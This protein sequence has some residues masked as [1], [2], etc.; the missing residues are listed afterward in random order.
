M[1]LLYKRFVYRIEIVCLFV[2]RQA[3]HN[4]TSQELHIYSPS[5]THRGSGGWLLY[6]LFIIFSPHLTYGYPIAIHRWIYALVPKSRLSADLTFSFSPSQKDRIIQTFS[7]DYSLSINQSIAAYNRWNSNIIR[8]IVTC[9]GL[10]HRFIGYRDSFI[11]IMHNKSI[12]S[13]SFATLTWCNKLSSQALS[14]MKSYGPSLRRI[15]VSYSRS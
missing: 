8:W 4:N 5:L 9:R 2:S 14:N 6:V 13:S 1:Q 15:L 7:I 12:I 10:V 3:V 11:Y